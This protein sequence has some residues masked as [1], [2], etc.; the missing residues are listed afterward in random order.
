MTRWAWAAAWALCS[1]ACGA[2]PEPVR[3]EGA[4]DRALVLAGVADHGILPLAAALEARTATLALHAGALCAAPSQDSLRSA[5]RAWAEARVAY[6]ATQAFGFGPVEE[7]RLGRAMD[8]APLRLDAV[9][10]LLAE[11]EPITPALLVAR[12]AT[13]RGFGVLERLLFDPFVDDAEVLLRLTEAPR[14]CA[15]V[16]ALAHDLADSGAALAAAWR[17]GGGDFRG[18][19]AGAGRDARGFATQQAALSAVLGGL[20][21]A[22]RQAEEALAKPLG[23]LDGGVPQPDAALAL[24][25]GHG[26]PEVRAWLAAVQALYEARG[27]GQEA[28]GLADLVAA[29]DTPLSMML[30]G[31]LTEA[32][33]AVEAVPEPLDRAVLAE[34]E[35]VEAARAAIHEVLL[36]LAVDTSA[37]LG[38]T[39]TFSDND[40]D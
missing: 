25:S 8:F 19:L 23:R 27:D 28:V 13:V 5:R 36:R 30:Q 14:R 32:I 34:P 31:E 16:V 10:E 38:V 20:V 39:L 17:P 7:L 22:A 37:L 29:R 6:R 12:G 21:D 1:L 2:T 18:A 33:R 24:Y 40:G 35:A 4:V 15:Y 11:T 3:G 9:A 26:L